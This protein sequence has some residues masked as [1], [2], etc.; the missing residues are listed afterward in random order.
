LFKGLFLALLAAKKFV[1]IAI[2]AVLGFIGRIFAIKKKSKTLP[3]V[4]SEVIGNGP[5]R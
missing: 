1:F 5:D 4:P 2:V 3:S